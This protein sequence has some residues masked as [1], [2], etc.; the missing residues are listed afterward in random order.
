MSG[1][2]PGRLNQ[3]GIERHLLRMSGAMLANM[4]AGAAFALANLYWLGLLGAEAQAAVMLAGFPAMLLLALM[5]VIA[6][7]AGILIAQAMGAGDRD[8]AE[9]IFNEAFAATLLFM[10]AIG[11]IAW[12]GRDAI[13]GLLTADARTAAMMTAYLDW[14]IP[15]LV[16][17]LPLLVVAN[18]LEFTGDVRTAAIAQT[19]TVALN[20]AL[21][22]LLMFGAFGLPAMGVVGAGLA[23]FLA[24]AAVM[25]ALMG[26]VLRG[27]AGLHLR[28]A[29]WTSRPRTL[30][31]AVGLGLPAGF[32]S[33]LMAIA[34]LALA[35]ALRP[36][37]ADD[38]AA[39]GIGQRVL[40]IVAMPLSALAGATAI[41]VGHGHGAGLGERVRKTLRAALALSF[42][43]AGLLLL[44]LAGFAPSIV[45]AFSDDPAVVDAGGEFL[46]I[47]AIGLL[48]AAF[49][50]VVFATLAGMGDTRA[51]MFGE[52]A[53]T[54]VIA[55]AALAL[56]QIDGLAP[57]W[58]W[59]A[60]LLAAL[61][62]ALVAL[63]CLR[64]VR[65][66]SELPPEPLPDGVAAVP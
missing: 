40:Q 54:V 38:Q 10:G 23:T 26:F 66:R 55:V 13:A 59:L 27:G 25:L 56:T 20:A 6:T 29:V 58:L 61:A 51:G 21:A 53:Y 2:D 9:R 44:A 63:R 28:P 52:I 14:F 7:G 48:P 50:G 11:A 35:L 19:A 17:Q 57:T 47:A 30:R 12:T 37:G 4:L 49:C 39:F 8:R 42:A 34:L 1:F 5:P 46:R 41:L 64:D 45:G 24:S 60:M 22:P 33:A 32:E 16:I 3:G 36:F 15:A 43:V 65:R 18:A 62:Q 31:R